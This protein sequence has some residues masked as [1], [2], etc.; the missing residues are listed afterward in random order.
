ML[1]DA[2]D[3]YCQLM[4]LINTGV[5][6]LS[7]Y[8]AFVLQLPAYLAIYHTPGLHGRVPA[9]Y[10]DYLSTSLTFSPAA[11]LAAVHGPGKRCLA[12]SFAIRFY[13]S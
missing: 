8:I 4:L 10:L 3:R 5:L 6:A 7:G 13:P 11:E 2:A 1:R 12:L 9:E